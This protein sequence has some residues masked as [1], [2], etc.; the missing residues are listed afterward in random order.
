MNVTA[1]IV[2]EEAENVVVVPVSAV[3]RGNVVLVK[4]DFADGMSTPVSTIGGKE[5]NQAGMQTNKSGAPEG[6]KY[7]RVTTGLSDG[8]FIEIKEGLRVT[9]EIYIVTGVREN[10]TSSSS[11]SSGMMGGMS[12]PA[13]GMMPSGG[14]SGQMPTGGFGGGM[15]GS[16]SRP[17]FSGSGMQGRGGF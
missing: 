5:N 9:D 1:E 12:M 15:S 8:E 3:S 6:Y 16:G 17:N 11:S 10:A 14:F 7:V 4:E 13:G 2:L